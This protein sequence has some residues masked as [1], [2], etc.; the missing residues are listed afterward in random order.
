M[1]PVL[2]LTFPTIPDARGWFIPM[3][4]KSPEINARF[5]PHVWNRSWVQQN[6]SFSPRNV[7]RGLHFQRFPYEQAK[8]VQAVSGNIMD[9]V[10]D[11]RP[12][13]PHRYS[14]RSFNLGASNLLYVPRGFAHGFLVLSEY[15]HVLY[16]VDNA[17]SPT[18]E[19][20]LR[21]ND[22]DLKIKWPTANPIINA[23]DDAWPLL[24][25]VVGQDEQQY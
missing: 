23:R 20:G 15:A 14:Y 19:G 6:L 10:V 17:Y 18:S 25:H 5:S 9:V 4:F 22:P 24:E 16:R 8:L 2:L 11:C 7:L 12:A 13:S 3:D 21:W 1:E